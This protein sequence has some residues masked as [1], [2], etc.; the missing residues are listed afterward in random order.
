[1]LGGKPNLP[2]IRQ[3]RSRMFVKN[4]SCCHEKLHRFGADIV[5]AGL[6]RKRQMMSI[7]LPLA[8]TPVLRRKTAGIQYMGHMA[9]PRWVVP[10]RRVEKASARVRS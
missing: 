2:A 4:H 3:V 8:P 9:R 1:V 7:T 5:G 10:I 6:F